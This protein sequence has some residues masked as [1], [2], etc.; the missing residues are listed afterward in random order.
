MPHVVVLYA[1]S[2]TS[3]VVLYNMTDIVQHNAICCCLLGWLCSAAVTLQDQNLV[4]YC[5]LQPQPASYASSNVLI[6]GGFAKLQQSE[7][8]LCHCLCQ[9]VMSLTEASCRSRWSMSPADAALRTTSIVTSLSLSVYRLPSADRP[10]ARR[11]LRRSSTWEAG[12][13]WGKG[14]PGGRGGTC[15]LGVCCSDCKKV[16]GGKGQGHTDTG[17]GTLIRKWWT[18]GS[19]QEGPA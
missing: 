10:S 4:P 14:G 16:G 8:V 9:R 15:A 19:G 13:K 3:V 5:A 2:T 17:A 18:L 1:Q 6:S 7:G 12:G 11:Y